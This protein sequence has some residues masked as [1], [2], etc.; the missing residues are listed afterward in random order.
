MNKEF[1]EILQYNKPCIQK[2]FYDSLATDHPLCNGYIIGYNKKDDDNTWLKIRK[3]TMDIDSVTKE[4]KKNNFNII[5]IQKTEHLNKCKFLIEILFNYAKVKRPNGDKKE[6]WCKFSHPISNIISSLIIMMNSKNVIIPQN[7]KECKYV[8]S[9]VKIDDS[10]DDDDF[11][12]GLAGGLLI[13]GL[14][15][16]ISALIIDVFSKDIPD[17]IKTGISGEISKLVVLQDNEK[18]MYYYTRDK[19]HIL[20]TDKRFIKIENKVM[21]SEVYLNRIK[22]VNHIKNSIFSFDKVEVLEESGR[23][24]TFGIYEKDVCAYF[25]D[26]LNN[27]VKEIKRNIHRLIESPKEKPE[28][29]IKPT[30]IKEN[31]CSRCLDKYETSQSNICENCML[32]L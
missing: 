9:D 28:L 10:D 6:E 29:P 7:I 20:L 15:V 1:L 26:L 16:G 25:T 23:I 32:N 2:Y 19:I 31:I 13:G 8:E 4:L 3:T 14:L 12:G 5:F 18:P 30:I 17:S 11:F 24:E 22:F 21:V 27:I